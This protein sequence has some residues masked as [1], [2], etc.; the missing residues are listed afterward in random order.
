MKIGTVLKE[1]RNKKGLTQMQVIK[2]I[3]FSQTALSQIETNNKYPS[4]ATVKK[5]CVLYD[6]APVLVLWMTVTEADIPKSKIDLYKK[7]KPVIDS[8]VKECLQ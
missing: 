1:L 6:T 3:K 4:R 8:I 2:K 5:L 7:I